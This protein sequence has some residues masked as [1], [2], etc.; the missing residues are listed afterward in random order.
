VLGRELTFA[1]T[2]VGAEIVH[3]LVGGTGGAL[4]GAL[5][6]RR[7]RNPVF[8]GAAFGFVLWLVGE[9]VAMSVLG[10][11]DPP[12]SYSIA[13]HANSLGEHLA[14]GIATGLISTALLAIP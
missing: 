5:L 3:F 4:Y 14:Y 6:G 7:G 13:M 8:A 1:E 12:Q 11:N 9:E 2:K 10:I